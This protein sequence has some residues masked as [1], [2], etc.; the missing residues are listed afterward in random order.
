MFLGSWP[1]S[2]IGDQGLQHNNLHNLQ[3]IS[4]TICKIYLAQSAKLAIAWASILLRNNLMTDN[5]AFKAGY[6]EMAS[7]S[8]RND[9]ADDIRVCEIAIGLCRVAT[10]AGEA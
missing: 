2:Y 9:F 6:M 4:C 3:N 8:I 1:A 7:C 10:L 5:R